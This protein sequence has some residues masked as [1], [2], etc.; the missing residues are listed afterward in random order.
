MALRNLHRSFF[1]TV[2]LSALV[3][4]P[5]LMAGC[6]AKQEPPAQGR[7]E[8]QSE[9]VSAPPNGASAGRSTGGEDT[10]GAADA[11]ASPPSA[12]SGDKTV[13]RSVEET[14]LYRLA[15]DRLFYLNAY[16]GLMVF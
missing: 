14:D 6:G 3:T 13:A 9:F 7:E 2:T 15:G 4:G 11:G 10:A 12:P 16:R 1:C 8:G 5:S